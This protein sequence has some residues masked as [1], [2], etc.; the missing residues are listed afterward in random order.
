M[1]T[2]PFLQKVL[3][4]TAEGQVPAIRLLNV[5]IN[6]F[7]RS[8]WVHLS[9]KDLYLITALIDVA[10]YLT[11]TSLSGRA[12][13]QFTVWV[14]S[15]HPDEEDTTEGVTVAVV[16]GAHGSCL[17]WICSQDWGKNQG[18]PSACFSHLLSP[19]PQSKKWCCQCSGWIFPSCINF[20]IK[21]SRDTQSCVSWRFDI[22]SS[23]HSRLIITHTHTH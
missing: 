12:L 16:A 15:D 11:N 4:N 20:S 13:F 18:S 9:F 10:E 5:K 14:Y 3:N 21:V 23:Q 1:G 19:E 6:S 2:A 7:V 22:T 17:G 8:Q